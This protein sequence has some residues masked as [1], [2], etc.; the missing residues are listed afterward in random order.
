M[1]AEARMS[2]EKAQRVMINAARLADKLG[3]EQDVAGELERERKVTKSQVK[4][5]HTRCERA[6]CDERPQ[7]RQEGRQKDGVPHLLAG[8]RD[9]GRVQ[10]I[11]RFQ[12]EL[13]EV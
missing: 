1:A 10:E 11:W 8:F 7:E 6:E 2:E 9:R 4:D 13:L 3:M 12:R 5:A